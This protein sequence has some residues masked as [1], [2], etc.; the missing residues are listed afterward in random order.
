MF[1]YFESS[2]VIEH[3]VAT[4][5]FDAL[6]LVLADLREGVIINDALDRRVAPIDELQAGFET[7]VQQQVAAFAPDV[8]WSDPLEMLSTESNPDAWRDWI[9]LHPTNVAAL[10][11]Y[12]KMLIDAQRWDEARD[13]LQTAVKL[14]PTARGEENPA[15]L[16]AIVFRQLNDTAQ[17]RTALTT[18]AEHDPSATDV[19]LRL[20]D[21]ATETNDW[22]AVRTHALQAI[23]VNPLIPQP[24]RALADAAEHLSL[25]DDC[26]AACRTLLILPRDDDAELHF[27]LARLLADKGEA[28]EAR[29]QTLLALERAPRYRDAQSLL[30]KLVRASATTPKDSP[31]APDDATTGQ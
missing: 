1:A 17:E 21:L 25:P 13:V 30:L 7:F 31:P 28:D 16:L 15:R 26:I 12:G 8:D 27:R 19:Y 3:I 22:Q 18:Y 11:I 24:H 10:T 2:L 29:R 4:Y 23:A 6:K 9:A 20:I 14:N 5:G